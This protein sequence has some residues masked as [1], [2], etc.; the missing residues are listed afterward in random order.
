MAISNQPDY[1]PL[2]EAGFHPMTLADVREL[3]VV[4][5]TNSANRRKIM[6]GLE[7]IISEMQRVGIEA[8][9]W[10][11]GSFLTKK[12]EPN[13]ADIVL[14]VDFAFAESC[15][16]EQNAVLNWIVGNL[17]SSHLCDSY[18]FVRFPNGHPLFWVGEWTH[19]YWV[20][21]FGFSRQ[22][23]FKGL[24]LINVSK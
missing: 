2:L 6:E 19:A 11:D 17:K 5:F 3:C 24:A 4:P 15:T 22:N 9:V 21:Q 14:C 1:P 12:D 23:G 7:R 13:D 20:R 16:S 18:V 8:Q 10:V